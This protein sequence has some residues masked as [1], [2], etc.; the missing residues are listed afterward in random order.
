MRTRFPDDELSLQ[1]LCSPEQLA[2]LENGAI[3][4]GFLHGPIAD[5][6]IASEVILHE[7]IVARWTGDHAR[8][9]VFSQVCSPGLRRLSF[10]P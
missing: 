8:L 3:D 2:A 7:T 9:E 6:E 10:R 1:S 4:V 5:P